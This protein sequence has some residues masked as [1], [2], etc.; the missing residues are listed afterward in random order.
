MLES[1]IVEGVQLLGLE[2][3]QGSRWLREWGVNLE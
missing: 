3:D 1:E 2:D